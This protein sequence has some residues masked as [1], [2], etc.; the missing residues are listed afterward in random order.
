MTKNIEQF[1]EKI[2]IADLAF[3]SGDNVKTVVT[4]KEARTILE[5]LYNQE[6]IS[7]EDRCKFPCFCIHVTLMAA[8]ANELELAAEFASI[9][10]SQIADNFETFYNTYILAKSEME[11]EKAKNILKLINKQFLEFVPYIHNHPFASK[12]IFDNNDPHVLNVIR[13]QLDAIGWQSW[14]YPIEIINKIKYYSALSLTEICQ[15]YL[16]ISPSGENIQNAQTAYQNSLELLNDLPDNRFILQLKADI[17][18]GLGQIYYLYKNYDDIK[19]LVIPYFEKS[20]S[21]MESIGEIKKAAIERNNIGAIYI[22]LAGFAKANDENIEAEELYHSAEENLI[23]AKKDLNDEDA[24]GVL[25]NLATLYLSQ[26][27]QDKAIEINK[28][29]LEYSY[30]TPQNKASILINLGCALKEKNQL[31]DAEKYLY[32]AMEVLEKSSNIL[33]ELYINVYE[34]LGIILQS[35]NKYSDAYPF[36]NK[37]MELLEPYISTF[38]FEKTRISLMKTHR[39][40]YEAAIN[41]YAD[42]GAAK[43]QMQ[44]ELWLKAFN[45]AEHIKWHLSV[46]ALRFRELETPAGCINPDMFQEERKLL[47]QI[48][49]MALKGASTNTGEID[50]VAIY[51]RLNIIWSELEP[52]YP[53]YVAIRKGITAKVDDVKKILDDEVPMLIEYYIGEEFQTVFAF[54]LQK[55]K[56]FPQ[57]IKLDITPEELGN[58]VKELRMNIENSPDFMEEFFHKNEILNNFNKISNKIFDA[59]VKPILLYIPEETGICIVPNKIL[60]NLPFNALYDGQRYF[61]ER[62]PIVIAPSTT[63]LKWGVNNNNQKADRNLVF[64]ATSGINEVQNLYI[65]EKLAQEK[66]APLFKEHKI[67]KGKDATKKRLKQEMGLQRQNGYWDIIHI[68]GHGIFASGNS[69]DSRLIMAEDPS[70]QNKD[71]SAIEIFTE[72]RSKATLVTLSACETGVSDVSTCDELFGLTH[73]FLFGGAS[74][75]LSSQWKVRQDVGES[76]IERFYKLWKSSDRNQAK[77][78]KIKALQIAQKDVL[79]KKEFLGLSKPW[80]HPNLWAAFQL[81]GDWR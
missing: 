71:I 9:L 70:E 66:I 65:F 79:L 61:I 68:A 27:Q 80:E 51:K 34:N 76:I 33:P 60:H 48:A 50:I 45:I 81:Y 30:N 29:L 43:P 12:L 47:K 73:A 32:E 77:Y 8:L 23:A 21:I 15:M 1:Y 52:Y 24:I 40:V 54:I 10:M 13:P 17:Y 49:D 38:S 26:N 14:L 72:I 5:V 4:L 20:I 35:Q 18:N 41:C 63:A 11:N 28:K 53:D 58:Y 57:I 6:N 75:V 39:Q 3:S 44:Q 55:G 7:F 22:K 2:G 78:S 64:C 42:L 37:A 31:A 74:S 67:I 25:A 46:S 69:L 36:L 56:D 59:L 19:T 16:Y 62:N